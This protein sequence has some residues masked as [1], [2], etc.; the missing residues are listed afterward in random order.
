MEYR[1]LGHTD[2][3]VSALCLGTMT[4]GKQNTQQDAS[5]QLDYA[6]ER[7]IN[8]I[9]TA[10]MYPVPPETETQG[11]TETMI[12]H[13]LANRRR[14]DDLVI[15]TKISGPG[16]STVRGG[17]GDYSPENIRLAVDESLQRLQTDFIDLFQLHW[18][19]RNSNFFGKLGYTPRGDE[20]DPAED[21]LAVLTTLGELVQAG[22]IR[23]VGLSNES[24]WG[25]MKFLEL[26]ER[27]GLP[28]MVSVQNP[29]N[30]LNRSYEVGLA[31]V[32]HRENVG[33]LPYSPLAFGVLSGKYLNGRQPEN[34]RLTLFER[35]SRY[36][37]A[38][39]VRATEAYVQL[40]QEHNLDPARM[41]LAWV[42]SRPFVTSNIIGATTMEQL[43]NDI[44]SADLRLDDDV[45]D[46]I[47]AIHAEA[48]NPC[49]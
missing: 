3:E 49:P 10:E 38:P 43:E 1:K 32:S 48:P 36:T 46:A 4:Y 22:K 45:L 8:F 17:K 47:E 20:S 41:A 42:T 39:G 9:D 7:G 34:A 40:A 33:L 14:R 25:T 29:Y 13:W 2:I 11:D 23:H 26:A 6:V 31:E 24:A 35:F 12:G 44:D 19:A 5:S 28:R 27:H 21:M 16:L 15:A 37:K 30:L 18:P